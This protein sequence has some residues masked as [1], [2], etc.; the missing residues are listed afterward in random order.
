V[1]VSAVIPTYNRAYIILEALESVRTQTYRDFEIIVVD[2]GS[3][4]GTAELVKS[5]GSEQIRYIRHERNKGCSAAYNTGI[6]AASGD[7][8]GF[9]DSDDKWKPDYLEQQV[10]FFKRHPEVDAVFTDTE[11]RYSTWHAPSLISLMRAFPRLLKTHPQAEESVLSTREMYLCLLEEVPIKPSA[12]VVKRDLFATAG[13]FDEEWP[14][15]TDWELFLRFSRSARFG[16]INRAL[17]DQRQTS[18]S[19][20]L[21]FVE[22]DKELLLKVALRE[23]ARLRDDPEAMRAV[24]RGISSHCSNLAWIYLNSGRSM[25]SAGLY[26]KG[27]TETHEFIMLARAASA[28]LPPGFRNFLKRTVRPAPEGQGTLKK[29]PGA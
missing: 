17:V 26:L 1:K 27:F 8:V 5:L 6:A 20:F 25:K 28:V 29:Q 13:T 19:T 2:D 9:L 16:F 12:V 3:I 14:S 15:G 4:D 23:K 11:I 22:K 24:N 10:S 7:L 18:D 21:R